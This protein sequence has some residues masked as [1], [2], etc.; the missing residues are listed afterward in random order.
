MIP[1][2]FLP[3]LAF[4]FLWVMPGLGQDGGKRLEKEESG[5]RIHP[6][7]VQTQVEL[8]ELSHQDLVTLLDKF[9]PASDATGLRIKVQDL[10]RAKRAVV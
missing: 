9:D 2:V 4:A 5:E 3:A 10:V 7:L 6:Q 1:R 8:I